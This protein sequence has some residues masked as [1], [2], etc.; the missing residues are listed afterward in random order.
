MFGKFD[1]AKILVVLTSFLPTS[2]KNKLQSLPHWA[3][4][5]VGAIG[6][7]LVS[8]IS[9][10]SSHQVDTTLMVGVL[11]VINWFIGFNPEKP[12][13]TNGEA[14]DSFAG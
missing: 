3:F 2:W 4:A 12:A 9:W 5:L 11:A 7:G 8:F 6:T 14:D 1:L 10:S 13:L